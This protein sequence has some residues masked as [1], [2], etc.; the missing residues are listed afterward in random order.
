MAVR[1]I[2]HEE[3]HKY[4][5]GRGYFVPNEGTAKWAEILK[6]ITVQRAAA[7]CSSGEVGLL[8]ILPRVT[9]ELVLFDHGKGSL[10]IAMAKYLL[11]SKL[12]PTEML[13]LFTTGSADQFRAAVE[14][15]RKYVPYNGRYDRLS[16]L[17][18]R[19]SEIRSEWRGVTLANVA[20]VKRRLAR[21]KFMHGDLT[22]LI[23]SGPYDLLY[24]SNA[25]EHPDR[26]G[27]TPDMSK[28]TKIV[29]PGGNV[30]VAEKPYH[31]LGS[32]LPKTWTCVK[33][34][35][36][37]GSMYWTQTLYTTPA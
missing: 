9:K 8:S 26:T 25:H 20:S 37:C 7:I 28:L 5:G 34:L 16:T 13:E 33:Q 12:T 14:S 10:S 2:Q 24:I 11:L 19:S 17:P 3:T 31:E 6:G 1:A 21:V 4:E 32:R 36:G 15:V 23:P 27:A 30:L 35:S 22:D 29:K 18:Y